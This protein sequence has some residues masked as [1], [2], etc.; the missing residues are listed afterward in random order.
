M[1]S[2]AASGSKR[3]RRVSFSS[4]TD[5]AMAP[6]PSTRAYIYVP[7]VHKNLNNVYIARLLEAMV[8]STCQSVETA[9]AMVQDSA[10][11][12]TTSHLMSIGM[13]GSNIRV[14]SHHKSVID[15]IAG[16]FGTL[17]DVACD[18][19][20]FRLLGVDN[21]RVSLACDDLTGHLHTDSSPNP[22]SP[23]SAGGRW[24]AMIHS[25]G[26]QYLNSLRVFIMKG[27]FAST[28]LFVCTYCVR[29]VSQNGAPMR[30]FSDP[31]GYQLLTSAF[32]EAGYAVLRSY[33]KTYRRDNSATGQNGARMHFSALLVCK[34]SDVMPE[35]ADALTDFATRARINLNRYNAGALFEQMQDAFRDYKREKAASG[36]TSHVRNINVLPVVDVAIADALRETTR[37]SAPSSVVGRAPIEFSG[38]ASI[39][40]GDDTT[41][42][43]YMA[44]EAIGESLLFTRCVVGTSDD[45]DDSDDEAGLDT[46]RESTL[47]STCYSPP[48]T[49]GRSSTSANSVDVHV[50]SLPV[51]GDCTDGGTGNDTI[52]DDATFTTGDPS[53]KT[54]RLLRVRKRCQSSSSLDNNKCYSLPSPKR[55]RVPPSGVSRHGVRVNVTNAGDNATTVVREAKNETTSE[56]RKEASA[57]S[58]KN[59]KVSEEEETRRKRLEM[60]RILRMTARNFSARSKKNCGVTSRQKDEPTLYWRRHYGT[61]VLAVQDLWAW[62]NKYDMDFK[63]PTSMSK[64]LFDN[65]CGYPTQRC[66]P[67]IDGC[68][69]R[70]IKL[71]DFD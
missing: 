20:L 38:T 58:R 52:S 48:R 13:R 53:T 40:T 42:E 49:R 65:D 44:G 17:G 26:A 62:L 16:S 57:A 51:A 56:K 6:T 37:A 18:P 43:E 33:Y 61:H 60:I 23:S 30:D 5:M 29:Q 3:S 9:R 19:N 63:S 34:V 36:R 15:G 8:A 35:H 21:M 4:V 68:R 64:F 27:G 10:C 1:P 50:S 14:V 41:D 54:R 66:M 7:S 47:R 24:D 46:S 71:S 59:G 45:G 31:I 67:R 2:R 22:L 11:G 70:A 39:G 28:A 25:G 12:N 32:R 55:R 69:K